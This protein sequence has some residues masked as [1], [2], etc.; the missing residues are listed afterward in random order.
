MMGKMKAPFQLAAEADPTFFA[1]Y[2]ALT[3]LLGASSVVG[4][5]AAATRA[6][7][8]KSEDPGVG[9]LRPTG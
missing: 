4:K 9:P 1:E 2:P 3:R 8:S 6:R 7:K 5:R